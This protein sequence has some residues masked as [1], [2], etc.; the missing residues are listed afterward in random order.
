MHQAVHCGHRRHGVLE[1]LV[2]LREHQIAAHQ[3][4]APLVSLGQKGEE[5]FHLLPRLLNVSQV[6]QNDGLK[7]VQLLEQSIQAQ[8][9]L[10]GQQL[11]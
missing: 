5:H 8:F 7:A 1:N 9:L 3:Q 6:V 11:S 10:G 4:A 2:P